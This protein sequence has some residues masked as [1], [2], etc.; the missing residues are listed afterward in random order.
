MK[1]VRKNTENVKIE[2]KIYKKSNISDEYR[3][4]ERERFGGKK[5]KQRVKLLFC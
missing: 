3:K 4:V 2:N 5:G 1:N